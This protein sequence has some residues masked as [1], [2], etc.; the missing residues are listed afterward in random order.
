MQKCVLRLEKQ[1]TPKPKRVQVPSNIW[2]NGL[3][4]IFNAVGVEATNI[5]REKIFFYIFSVLASYLRD[6][7]HTYFRMGYI[8]I[9]KD[10]FNEQK[11][12][13][14]VLNDLKK[15]PTAVELE[16]YYTQGGLEAE[17]VSE[18]IEPFL[19][20]LAE[21]STRQEKATTKLLKCKDYESIVERKRR[22]HR[23]SMRRYRAKLRKKKKEEQRKEKRL[24]QKI[25][26]SRGLED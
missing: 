10:S 6:N 8:D 14:V 4:Q 11:L 16:R 15:I 7:A 9:L 5:Q 3:K 25:K 21:Y 20:N 22:Q 24:I 17:K 26:D 13:T 23:M 12:F 18:M 19:E 1:V 2:D